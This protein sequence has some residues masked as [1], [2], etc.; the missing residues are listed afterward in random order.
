MVN[1]CIDL[2]SGLGG[3][4]ENFKQN[5]DWLTIRVDINR[6]FKPDIIADV[7]KLPVKNGLKPDIVV[8][9]PPCERFSIANRRFPKKGIKAALEVVGACLESIVDLE[10]KYWVLENPKGRLRW[11]L[12]KPKQTISLSN[13][14]AK[15][16][17]PTD[18]WGNIQLPFVNA[19][20]PYEPS[21][22]SNDGKNRLFK[23]EERAKM[24]IGL[25]IA[26]F[27]TVKPK[28]P[29]DQW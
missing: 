6:K 13:Y 5:K 12:G 11:F 7:R 2:C 16:K 24:P 29:I 28:V 8:A 1:I 22:S 18:L 20:L 3:L 10:A 17:K 21:W 14:G 25:S 23:P 26:L 27:E 19:I 4:S 15:Y 9:S